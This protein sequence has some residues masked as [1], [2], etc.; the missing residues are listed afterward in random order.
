M[1]PWSLDFSNW[2]KLF[3]LTS[4]EIAVVHP[5]EGYYNFNL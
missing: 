1:G 4:P 5:L 2:K 3:K